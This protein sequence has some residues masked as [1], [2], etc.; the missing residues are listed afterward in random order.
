MNGVALLQGEISP[1][2]LLAALQ[3]IEARFGRV[4]GVSNAA[5]TLDLDIISMGT[6]VREPPDDPVLPHP[7]AHTRDFVLRPLAPPADWIAE[8]ESLA[9]AVVDLQT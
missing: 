2:T 5:R 1:Q 9:E 8:L 4:R 7:R 6:L 3:V